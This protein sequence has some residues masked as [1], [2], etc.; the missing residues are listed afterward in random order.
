MDRHVAGLFLSD[1]E[2]SGIH[3]DEEQ[4]KSVVGLNNYTLQIGQ[5]FMAGTLEP[6]L[7]SSSAVPT[8]IRQ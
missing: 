2:Q 4:R 7:I 1:F 8:E 6:R 3:L 5:R